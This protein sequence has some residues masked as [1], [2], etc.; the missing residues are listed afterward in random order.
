MSIASSM[1]AFEGGQ[2]YITGGRGPAGP[3]GPAGSATLPM[4]C[5]EDIL[6]NRLVYATGGLIYHADKDTP[7]K[8]KVIGLST[9]SVS[10]GGSVEIL[11]FG[12]KF[13]GSFGFPSSGNLWLG[14]NGQLVTTAPTSGTLVLVGTITSASSLIINIQQ[15]LKLI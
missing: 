11:T 5:G 8:T 12:E 7:S 3:T 6:V 10:S 9:Q 2:V 15:G 1:L 13:D 4:N 14:S